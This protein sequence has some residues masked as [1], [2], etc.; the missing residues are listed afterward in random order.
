MPL[1]DAMN[2][3]MSEAF[4]PFSASPMTNGEGGLPVNIYEDGDS[5]Y[6]QVA[7]PGVSPESV[8]IT[9]A[10]GVINLAVRQESLGKEGWKQ[11]WQ[12]FQP[13]EFRR[14]LRLPVEFDASKIEATYE[15][16]VLQ[17]RV[18]KAEHTRPR[19]IK[20]NVAK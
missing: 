12:E 3:L 6:L 16:G 9:A 2:Q 17:L 8:E 10:N 5:Y 20:V 15:S 7:A 19:Q 18:P 13:T 4:A 1:R 14:Q 11:L